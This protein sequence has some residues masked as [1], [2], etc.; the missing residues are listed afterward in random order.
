MSGIRLARPDLLQQ[1]GYQTT[2][3]RPAPADSQIRLHCN[4]NPWPA[5]GHDDPLVNRYPERQPADLCERLAARYGVA[6]ENVLLTRGADDAIDAVIRGFCLPGRSMIAQCVPT[7]AMYAF[8]ARLHGVTVRD[9]PPRDDPQWSAN[10]DGLREAARDGARLLFV[11]SPNN[12][13]GSLTPAK[14]ILQLCR[15][16]TDQALVV[17][18][19]AYIEFADHP[20]VSRQVRS[21]SNL[22]VLRTLSKAW[23]L[24]GARIGVLLASPELVRYLGLRVLP[25]YPLPRPSV[26]AALAALEAT[27]PQILEQRIGEIRQR[28]ESLGR[29]LAG[30]SC[31]RRVCPGQANFLLLEMDNAAALVEACREQGV[32]VRDQSDQPGLANHVRISIGS[33]PET[34]RLLQVFRN[35]EVRT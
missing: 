18:D 13:T 32:L 29:L 28:R 2:L 10:L 33:G 24:A 9:V 26:Q 15:D 30:F 35:L 3:S 31:V 14:R 17:A 22:V 4:E 27:T 11:C 25:P 16:V 12:P 7:F 20:G 8:F 21:L 1:A 6:E 19:E 5:A 23:S 34:D